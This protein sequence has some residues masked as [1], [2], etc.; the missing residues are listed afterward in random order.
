MAPPYSPVVRSGDFLICSGQ[1]GQADGQL[2]DGLRAQVHQAMKNI[3][4]LLAAH[5]SGLHDVVKVT[6][7][8]ADIG[9][10]TDFFAG[11]PDPRLA[12]LSFAV[13]LTLAFAFGAT[14]TG[15]IFMQME[16]R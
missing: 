4:D 12:A 9:H 5:G 7:L 15:Y 2:A 6:V 8:L 13:N 14:L 16:K 3:S 11:K 1:V 10:L